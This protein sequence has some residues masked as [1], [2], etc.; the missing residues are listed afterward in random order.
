MS[1]SNCRTGKYAYSSKA[2]AKAELKRAKRDLPTLKHVYLC[3]FCN[4]WHMT[5]QKARV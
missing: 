3:P 2:I 4:K 5:S 1:H